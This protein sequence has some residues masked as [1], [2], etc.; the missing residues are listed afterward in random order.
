MV[1]VHAR[2]IRS[3]EQAGKL[4]RE[5]EFLPNDEEL[6]ERQAAGGGLTAP[7][8]AILLSYTKIALYEELLASDLP[9]DPYLVEASSSAT[10]RRRCASGSARR[11]QR[12]PLRRE[13]IA[14]RVVND[15]VN[16]AGTT[17][18]FR[19]REETGARRRDIARAYTV[20][21]EVFDLRGL[22]AEIEALDGHDRRR[23]AG[24]DAAQGADPARARDALA[25]AQPAPA[26]RHRRRRSPASRRA[27]RR[28]PRRCP[29]C[30]ARPSA[31]P[32][33]RRP[34][35]S[36]AAGVPTALAQRVAH[37]EA[38]V[39]ALDIVEIAA[40]AELDVVAVAD[41]YFSLGA[42][43]EL[44]WLRDR[45]VALPRETRWEAMARAALR[46][47][48]YS[49][50]AALTAEVLQ[51]GRDAGAAAGGDW[52][53]ENAGA[54]ERCAAGARGHQDGRRARPRPAVRRRARDPQPDPLER[55]A[56]AGAAARCKAVASTPFSKPSCASSSVSIATS[57][58]SPSSR[59]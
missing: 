1:D 53:A 23:D 57:L 52:L 7:E 9:D 33:E 54:V 44:Q 51:P 13:I 14:T 32:R 41:V 36:S 3:L 28:S 6:A 22:W 38:L 19:L 35:R 49:E 43:L 27:R 5:L 18:A 40:A 8:F 21:R 29:S 31:R 45:I 17:F 10:S 50:Q 56:G 59:L 26:A 15:L 20:A 25:P 55:L 12:H 48:V 47:D 42:R 4:D 30:S 37:L 34:R 2:Y 46:D 11:S 39:P 58:P 24:R 16:R